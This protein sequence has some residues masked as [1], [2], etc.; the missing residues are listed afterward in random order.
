MN[1][2]QIDFGYNGF[3]KQRPYKLDFGH[4]Y[5]DLYAVTGGKVDCNY[6]GILWTTIDGVPGWYGFVDGWLASDQA[7][8][9]KTM[10]PGG[11]SVKTE[12]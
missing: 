12:W 5:Y 11:M 3:V 9:K 8:M 10:V 2:G 4:D 1:N 7:L 6:D